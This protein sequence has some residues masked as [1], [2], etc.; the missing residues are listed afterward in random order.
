[1]A[2]IYF[3]IEI[4]LFLCTFE[5]KYISIETIAPFRYKKHLLNCHAHLL[6]GTNQGNKLMKMKRTHHFKFSV[7]ENQNLNIC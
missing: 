3:M 6:R 1:M 2:S 5:M 7:K 4:R